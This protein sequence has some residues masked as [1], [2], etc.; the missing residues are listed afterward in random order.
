MTRRKSIAY[1]GQWNSPGYTPA[2]DLGALLRHHCVGEPDEA[3]Q[4]YNPQSTPARWQA[5]RSLTVSI[6]WSSRCFCFPADKLCAPGR[7][8]L[9]RAA[10]GGAGLEYAEDSDPGVPDLTGT[11]WTFSTAEGA[12]PGQRCRMVSD[13][14]VYEAAAR[15]F[16]AGA[17]RLS[18]PTNREFLWPGRQILYRKL[19]QASGCRCRTA[20]RARLGVGSRRCAQRRKVQY[21]GWDLERFFV[22]DPSRGDAFADHSFSRPR[23]SCAEVAAGGAEH[24]IRLEGYTFES[25]P[26]AEVVAARA[27]PAWKWRYCWRRTS[28][29]GDRPA[30]MVV[31]Q[32][33][34][35]GGRV[36][37]FRS[38]RQRD[39]RPLR[40]PARQVLVLDGKT[41]LIG[42]E[43][44]SGTSFP[45]TTRRTAPSASG[46]HPRHGRAFSR[47]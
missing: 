14:L 16:Q 41:A 25:A 47:G 44:L 36:Y 19:D 2:A 31:Q 46:R 32:I 11:S 5:G 12:D 18:G 37:Y 22:P 39:Q 24:S 4:I 38:I 7:R 13:T 20:T 40:V 43:N 23:L 10:L 34:E 26:L 45:T 42:S 3:F 35:A 27:R 8:P 9:S 15:M 30:K 17:D 1:G 29:R 21:A 6:P 33:A 28:G